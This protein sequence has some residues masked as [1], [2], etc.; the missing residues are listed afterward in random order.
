[1]DDSVFA[2]VEFPGGTRNP[3]RRHD[4]EANFDSTG[5]DGQ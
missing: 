5:R 1:M 4:I 2:T 3:P